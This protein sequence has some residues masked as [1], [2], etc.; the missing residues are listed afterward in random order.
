M[1]RP[2][3]GKRDR[4]AS[5][6]ERSEVLAGGEATLRQ[7]VHGG[8]DQVEGDARQQCAGSDP[9]EGVERG[10]GGV[11]VEVCEDPDELGVESRGFGGDGVVGHLWQQRPTFAFQLGQT[12]A[13]GK[14]RLRVA[15]A[16][17]RVG[18]PMALD[19]PDDLRGVA[20]HEDPQVRGRHTQWCRKYP[21]VSCQAGRIASRM[22]SPIGPS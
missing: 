13:Q 19:R 21:C 10:L 14:Q 5:A 4:Y 16:A 18:G 15:G 7:V 2:P 22:R 8:D 12:L 20:I 11:D 3:P 9:V 1:A 17:G 6:C